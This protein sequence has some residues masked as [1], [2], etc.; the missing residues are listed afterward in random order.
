M[1]KSIVAA[2]A[3]LLIAWPIRTHATQ[4]DQQPEAPLYMPGINYNLPTVKVSAAEI[5]RTRSEMVEKRQVDIPIRMIDCGGDEGGH[6]VGVS[7]VVRFKGQ[8]YAGAVHDQVS[9][10][11]HILGG[12]GTM[13]VGGKLTNAKRRPV[14]FPRAPTHC[15]RTTTACASRSTQSSTT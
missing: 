4:D 15:T 9:E 6:Q 8:L 13:V 2:A 7:L 10:V 14:A 11:Y 3:V 5:E 12:A 1:P